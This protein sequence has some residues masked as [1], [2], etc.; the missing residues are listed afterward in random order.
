MTP[1][2]V[3]FIEASGAI[4]IGKSK[5]P[6]QRLQQF[7]THNP[8]KIIVHALIPSADMDSLEKRLHVWLTIYHIKGEWFRLEGALE[9]IIVGFRAGLRKTEFDLGLLLASY[10]HRDRVM[11]EQENRQ[12]KRNIASLRFT[13]RIA[14]A[15]DY[16]IGS[17]GIRNYPTFK[18][19]Y[20]E[21]MD[22]LTALPQNAI[23]ILIRD[24]GGQLKASIGDEAETDAA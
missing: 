1:G 12:L 20:D 2:F 3:Y 23:P 5:N 17:L 10:E 11:L 18:L 16:A 14:W 19:R 21:A 15:L 6:T 22:V 9:N 7:N 13:E 24:A 4:K 8:S